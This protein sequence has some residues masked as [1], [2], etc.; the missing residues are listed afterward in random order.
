MEKNVFIIRSKEDLYDAF[1]N[2]YSKRKKEWPALLRAHDSWYETLSGFHGWRNAVARGRASK[3]IMDKIISDMQ[4]IIA[5][6]SILAGRK[7]N[8]I[9]AAKYGLSNPATKYSRASK[10]A[11]DADIRKA[12]IKNRNLK[13]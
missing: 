5:T 9:T 7:P 3:D 12:K 2:L 6:E 10:A 13:P 4:S 8:A 11:S 1:Q